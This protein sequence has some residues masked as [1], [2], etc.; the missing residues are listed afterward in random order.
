MRIHRIYLPELNRG[1]NVVIGSEAQHLAQVLRVVPGVPVR[2]FDGCG[3]EADG[4]V[5]TVETGRVVI[6]LREPNSGRLEAG[7]AVTVAI[8]LL[9]GDKL[10][11]VVR[12]CTELGAV[13]FRP[14][15]SRRRDVPE[16]SA[17]KLERL[18][19]V[20]REAAKQSGR[21]VVPLVAEAVALPDLEVDGLALVAQPGAG[22][23]LL[24]VLGGGL[25]RRDAPETRLQRTNE[26]GA[27]RPPGHDS[28]SSAAEKITVVTGPEGGFTAEEVSDLESRGARA[29]RLGAR[30][31][32]AETAPVAM[33]AALLVPEAL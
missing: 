17:N 15:L 22:S 13:S 8:S 2:A 27:T 16:L 6:E 24:T 23:T 10:A 14:L 7:I 32:R 12:Q 25:Q 5:L 3:K 1:A 26:V 30:V 29:V 33:L 21:S 31:L 9:K 28:G 19:R 20:A 11:D 4:A 18:R